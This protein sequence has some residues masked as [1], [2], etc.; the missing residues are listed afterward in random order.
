M[1]SRGRLRTALRREEPDR[2]PIDFGQDY[3]N[4]I[5]EVAYQ[6]LLAY[7]KIDTPGPIA[8]YDLMQ[9]L[10]VVDERILERFHVD[11]RYITANPNENFAYKVEP[12]GSYEDEWGAIAGVAAITVKTFVRRWPAKASGKFCWKVCRHNKFYHLERRERF[13]SKC[14]V[15]AMIEAVKE[16]NG[17][18]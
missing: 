3:H 9:R 15:V 6:N 1:T 13:A 11:T 17:K 10:A 8:V 12:D 7:L 2:V 4:G 14:Y 18:R 16:F 5:N